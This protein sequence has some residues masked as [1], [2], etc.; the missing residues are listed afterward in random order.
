MKKIQNLKDLLIEQGR[1]LHSS[2]QQELK[3]L[4][5]IEKKAASAKLKK[6]INKETQRIKSQQTNLVN[7]FGKLNANPNGNQST[8]TKS[9]L[10]EANERINN[11]KTKEVCDACIVNS[12]QQ[13]GHKK[14]SDLGAISAYA[15]E[16]GNTE[17]ATIL[18]NSLNEEKQIGKELI[19]LA[20]KD[21]NRKAASAVTA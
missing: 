9:I 20:Q 12:L 10:S 13:L 6:I 4:P 2:Y 11:S 17:A 15:K 3:E 16:I 18:H 19:N 8:V 21:I 1:E 7:V 5:N 14:V